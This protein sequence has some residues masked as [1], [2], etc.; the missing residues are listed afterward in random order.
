MLLRK[1]DSS[2]ILTVA[3]DKE[4]KKLWIRFTSGDLYE[5]RGVEQ[6]VVQNLLEADSKGHF[7][8]E[9]IKDKYDYERVEEE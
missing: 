2:A 9:N 8:H 3:Y 1:V 7:V 5:Y 6:Q 4:E